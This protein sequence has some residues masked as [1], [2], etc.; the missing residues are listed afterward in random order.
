MNKTEAPVK[1]RRSFATRLSISIMICNLVLVLTCVLIIS[2]WISKII[3]NQAKAN[4]MNALEAAIGDIELIINDV[5]ACVDNTV[6]MVKDCLDEPEYMFTI[7]RQLEETT[8][9]IMGSAVAFVPHYF[10]D[11]GYWYAPYTCYD[12]PTKEHVSFQ[13][14]TPSNNY[15]KQ[16]WFTTPWNSKRPS[17][18]EPYFD[19]GGGLVN[20]TTY[21]NPVLN[22]KG[23]VIAVVT[24][25]VSLK[26]L[27]AM[28]EHVKPYKNSV[29]VA[30]SEQ[31]TF[32]THPDSS[33]VMTANYKDVFKSS[34]NPDL[35][36]IIS[37][38]ERD[39]K[40]FVDYEFNGKH[41]FMAYA[42]ISNGWAAFL[43]CE[44]DSVFAT[45]RQL[46]IFMVIVVALALLA[47][48]LFTS[49][50]IRRVARP[51]PVLSDAAI[52]LAEVAR[53]GKMPEHDELMEL[54]KIRTSDEISELI[55][56]FQILQHNIKDYVETKLFKE[57]VQ[58]DLD[59]ARNIQ[60]HLLPT[61]F[62]QNIYAFLQPAKEVGGD[63]YQ[64]MLKDDDHLYFIVGDVSGKGMPAALFMAA[65]CVA[66]ATIYDKD[67]DLGEMMG[68]INNVMSAR[69]PE[70]LFITAVLCRLNLKTGRLEMCNAG[71]NPGI[72]VEPDSEPRFLEMK[73]NIV[74]AVAPGYEFESQEIELKPGTRI[75]FYTDGV[76]EGINMREEQFG[77][78]RLL[79]CINAHKHDELKE[80]TMSVFDAVTT[81]AGE[82]EQFDDI[83]MLTIQF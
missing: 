1:K 21:S 36:R 77:E 38:V 32:L 83:T 16:S 4:T 22:S 48:G 82:R 26:D 17:W 15:F 29:M 59:Q 45:L 8:P 72:I 46:D 81:F 27:T 43:I 66:Y 39:E 52:Q 41:C 44:Y 62:T 64:F 71:H 28:V 49:K 67:K 55:T 5:E 79:E 14:G 75:F 13:L 12:S 80:M 68:R 35:L 65:T 47:L 33:L 69:N 6:W 31:G 34:G 18:C 42:P 2:S 40:G 19:Q 78:A 23:E 70:M 63:L 74:L 30:V 7:S 20:M 24:A 76:T 50:I 51:L 9:Y 60:L 54:P 3:V 58:N 61:N 57:K 25:D 53:E 56:S 73:R 10:P 11:K 37:K